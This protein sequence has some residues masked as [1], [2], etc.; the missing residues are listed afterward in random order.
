MF[1][2]AVLTSRRA[3]WFAAACSLVLGLFFIFVWSPLPFGWRGIDGYHELGIQ[4][5]RGDSYSTMHLMWG[6]AHFLGF[7]Y[8]IFGPRPWVPLVVQAVLNALVPFLIY[9]HARIVIDRR[10]AVTAALLAGVL[11]FNTVYVSTLSSDSLCTTIFVTGLLAFTLG[12][13][14]DRLA[15]FALAGALTS[16][17]YHLRPNLVVFPFFLCATYLIARPWRRRKTLHAAVTLTAFSVVA[18]PWIVRNYLLTGRFIPAST[19]GAV[20]LWYGT[21]QTGPHLH[22]RAL[23]PRSVFESPVF[24]Y[25]SLS[26][27]SIVIGANVQRAA[28]PAIQTRLVY[29]TDRDPRRTSLPPHD[30][31]GRR[32]RFVLAPQPAPTTVFYFFET[33]AQT[34][35]GTLTQLTPLDGSA[36]PRMFFVSDNHLGDL[37]RQGLLLDV[38]DLVRLLRHEQWD[39]PLPFADRLD[40]DDSGRA[41]RRD[42]MLAVGLLLGPATDRGREFRDDATA[43]VD[44]HA[45]AVILTLSDGSTLAVPRGWSGRITDVTVSP[46]LAEGLLFGRLSFAEARHA[47]AVAHGKAAPAAAADPR[48]LLGNIRVNDVFYRRDPH[49]LARYTALALDNIWRDPLAYGSSCLFR[50]LRV[51]IVVGTDDPRTTQQF[52]RGRIIFAAAT[53]ASGLLFALLI[54]GI[55]IAIRRGYRLLTLLTPVVYIPLTLGFVLVNMRYSVTVQ[56]YMFVFVA[57]ALDAVVR[58]ARVAP[59]RD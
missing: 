40:F 31:V 1:L 41:D 39:E 11:S 38:F 54:A 13:H 59:S 50:M 20:Q 3:V 8:R 18:A 26:D 12:V 57:I 14:R 2:D 10:I 7:W 6:Y 47:L 37:D 21:L 29:W 52:S 34:A 5:A 30:N 43:R 44:G 48:L 42:L 58:R 23:N 55:A 46:G 19:H 35:A 32:L 16:A 15:W 45:D 49:A 36:D 4:T 28:P 17:A 33:R 27:L 51:F 56:P 25:T 9:H 53:L 22:S 24:E